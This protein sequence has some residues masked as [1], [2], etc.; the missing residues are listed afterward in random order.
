M[1][2]TA[3]G[4]D[5]GA[6][7]VEFDNEESVYAFA[8]LV[9]EVHSSIQKRHGC[10]GMTYDDGLRSGTIGKIAV[11]VESA[12]VGHFG[13]GP[14]E[15]FSDI[16]DQA[17]YL[18]SHLAL[19]HIFADGNKRTA[20]IVALAFPM[21]RGI[22]LDLRDAASSDNNEPYRWIQDVVS[23]K[24]SESELADRLRGWS[25]TDFG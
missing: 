2:P 12:F 15:R 25:K 1:G 11:I 21:M 20:L 18:A 6:P 7:P 17:A 5:D 14:C 3:F 9:F 10:F 19:D 4:R 22:D 8:E 16:F 13:C 23:R 24:C